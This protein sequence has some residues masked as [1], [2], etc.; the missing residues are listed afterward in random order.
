MER[1]TMRLSNIQLDGTT[2]V[3]TLQPTWFLGGFVSLW[4]S[5]VAATSPA[6]ASLVPPSPVSSERSAMTFWED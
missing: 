2:V 3:P 6:V 1:E 5:L 4:P